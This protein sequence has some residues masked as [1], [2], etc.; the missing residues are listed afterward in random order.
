[1][2]TNEIITQEVI[3]GLKTKGLNWFKPWNDS[4]D[5]LAISYDSGKPYAGLNQFILSNAIADNDWS[6]NQF[7]TFKQITNAGGKVI[8]GEKA[9][10]V[11]YWMVS[12]MHIP[13]KKWYNNEKA[14]KAAG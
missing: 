8:K 11:T 9:S 3:K 6:C 7:A 2:K 14:L 13:T 10:I 4:Y 5:T 12:Y 1:M